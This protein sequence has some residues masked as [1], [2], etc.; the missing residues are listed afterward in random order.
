MFEPIIVK[1][2]DIFGL[3]EYVFV[4]Q[5]VGFLGWLNVVLVVTAGSLFGLRRLNKYVYGNKNTTLKKIVKPL[6][7]IHPYVGSALLISALIHGDLALGTVFKLHT[8]PLAGWILLLMM[9]V[10][11]IG[12]CPAWAAPGHTLAERIRGTWVLQQVSSC[13]ELERL[14]TTTVGAAL[15][16]PHIRGFC[17]RV[18][19]HAIDRDFALIESA[20]ELAQAHHVDC[21]IRFMAGR[22]T[23]QRVFASPSRTKAVRTFGEVPFED[24]FDHIPQRRLDDAV[25]NRRDGQRELHRSA[26]RIWDRRGLHIL[27]IR[28]EGRSSP[29]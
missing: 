12:I 26:A 17:I 5:V 14:Q 15:K 16:T 19:W 22:H 29:S 2:S 24:R 8:G 9:L 18:P 1:I 6:S 21:S 3:N 10:A 25:S 23:P 27:I 11:L 20:L 13:E 4:Y 7:K 28:C